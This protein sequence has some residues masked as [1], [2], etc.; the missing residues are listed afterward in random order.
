MKDMRL[1]L[2]GYDRLLLDAG[3]KKEECGDCRRCCVTPFL[4]TCSDLEAE[5]VFRWLDE[6]HLEKN[7]HFEVLADEESDKRAPYDSWTCPL[8]DRRSGK[9][10]VYHVRPYPCRIVG[11]MMADPSLLTG[12]KYKK[13]F[14]YKTPLEIVGWENYASILRKYDF[15]RGYFFPDG[16]LE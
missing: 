5:I 12:C 1:F 14:V 8:L 4:M 7:L 16:V 11:P 2:D 10:R 3:F 9:C 13:P 6:N 15:K